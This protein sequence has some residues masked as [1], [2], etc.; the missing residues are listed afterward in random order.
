M[1]RNREFRLGKAVLTAGLL[2]AGVAR[3]QTEVI[4]TEQTQAAIQAALDQRPAIV[5]LPPGR[6]QIDGTLRIRNND[7]LLR[8]SG[9]D[10]TV[11]FRMVDGTNTA[12]IRSTGFA[13]VRV[14]GIRFEGVS[15]LDED[16]H[17]LSTGREV[18]IMFDD[19][20]DFRVD[21]CFFTHTGFAGVRTNGASSGVVDHCTFQD[22]YKPLVGTDGYGVVVYGV[23]ALEEVPF[24]SGRATFIEDSSFSLCRHAVAS[25]KGARYVFRY[26]YVAQNEIAHAIDAHGTEYGSTVGTEWIDANNNLVEDPIY[27]GYAVRIRGGM[28]VIWNNTFIGYSLGIRL[29]QETPQPTGPV[30]IWDNSIVPETNPMVRAEGGSTYVLSPPNDYLPYPYPHPLVGGDGR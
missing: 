28:G 22:Q 14:T 5:T 24:G 26:N 8:G 20:T 12:M 15:I 4:V 17:Q 6:Y 13:R 16:L 25:N 27:T 23:D 2:I 3:A 21:N 18:G 30:Y 9:A 1:T 10:Q 19:A 7:L 11:L 29:T